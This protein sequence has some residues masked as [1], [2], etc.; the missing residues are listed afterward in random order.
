[1]CSIKRVLGSTA[2]Y[3]VSRDMRSSVPPRRLW[4]NAGHMVERY[5][6]CRQL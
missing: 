6:L 2:T 4:P 5:A 1:M 3:C